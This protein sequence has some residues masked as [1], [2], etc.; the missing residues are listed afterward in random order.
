MSTS[1][2]PKTDTETGFVTTN[3]GICK[4]RHLY[5]ER[6][7]PFVTADYAR[8]LEREL[9]A[10]NQRIAELEKDKARLDW[11]EAKLC[12]AMVSLNG[13]AMCSLPSGGHGW[14]NGRLRAAIDAERKETT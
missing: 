5:V 8:T 1:D 2:T 4:S 13:T 9:N 14:E 3:F 7:G 6:D 10:A 12:Y 11:L